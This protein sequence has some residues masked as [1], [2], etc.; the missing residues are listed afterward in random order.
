M[1]YLDLCRMRE[2]GYTSTKLHFANSWVKPLKYTALLCEGRVQN[3]H[4]VF[5][6]ATHG[7]RCSS[8][9]CSQTALHCC[10]RPLLDW[11]WI[12]C[13]RHK[14]SCTNRDVR[15]VTNTCTVPPLFLDY[16]TRYSH[17]IKNVKV[18]IYY[19]LLDNIY[20]QNIIYSNIYIFTFKSPQI[21]CTS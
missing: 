2:V 9:G 8:A 16:K 5:K 10:G 21:N 13:I 15:T 7:I 18:F 11:G 6:C 17:A 3:Q 20:K 14:A 19:I 4:I 12:A 1:E